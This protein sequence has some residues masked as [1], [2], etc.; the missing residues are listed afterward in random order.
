[1]I[2]SGK[3]CQYLRNEKWKMGLRMGKDIPL[4][5]ERIIYFRKKKGKRIYFEG[6]ISE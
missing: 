4:L 2:V 3:D 5:D 1:M 6:W